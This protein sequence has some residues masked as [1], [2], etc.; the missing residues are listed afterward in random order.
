MGSVYW[1]HCCSSFLHQSVRA[2]RWQEFE[3]HDV[4]RIGPVCGARLGDNISAL[5]AKYILLNLFP[6]KHGESIDSVIDNHIADANVVAADEAASY[7]SSWLFGIQFNMS[8]VE[9]PTFV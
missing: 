4:E 7:G 2:H 9:V 1:A 3:N 6:G 5:S 8:D